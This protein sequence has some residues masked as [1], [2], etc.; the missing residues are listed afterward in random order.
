LRLLAAVASSLTA[1]VLIGLLTGVLPGPP[2]RSRRNVAASRTWFRQAGLDVTSRQFWT[3]SIGAGVGSFLL[4]WL[5]SGMWTVAA[6]PALVTALLPRGWYS[7]RRM[8][9]VGEVQR[10][11][12]DGLRDLVASIA[13]GMSLSRAVETLAV[14]GPEPLRRAFERYPALVRTVGVIPALEVIKE[15]LAHP[16]SDRV[17]E[18]LILAHDRGGSV[19]PDILRDLANVTTRDVWAAEEIETA[20]LE[21]KINAR[22]VFVIPWMVLLL[23]TM[24]PGPFRQFYASAGGVLVIVLGGLLS[25]FG[26]W[27]VSRMGKDPD[28]PR[29]FGGLVA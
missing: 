23:I 26:I 3:A 11:W 4:L 29:V 15:E 27:V 21:Q 9:R 16:T 20:S 5:L 13:S 24:R 14:S 17:I 6:V 18:V 2:R 1:I 10:A 25:L 7:R 22:V 19:V 12:P 8:Q 28:E